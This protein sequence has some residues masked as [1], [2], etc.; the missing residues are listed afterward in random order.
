MTSP[1]EQALLSQQ[2]WMEYDNGSRWELPVGRWHEHSSTVDEVM[3]ARCQGPTLDVGC[4]PGRLT[5]ALLA[6]GA[7]TLGI[8]TSEAAV[9]MTVRRGGFALRRNVFEQV[10]CEGRWRHVLL[11]DGNLGIGGDPEGLLGRVHRL[12]ESGGSAVVEVAPPGTGLDSRLARI[13]GGPWFRWSDVGVDAIPRLAEATRFRLGWAA[14]R[15]GRWFVE[16]E[17][18]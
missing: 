4:G 1:F 7:A 10:P 3:L 6:R 15:A 12:L 16:L 11:A 18:M 13:G 2:C 5:L 14:E 9:R 8:D 17:R